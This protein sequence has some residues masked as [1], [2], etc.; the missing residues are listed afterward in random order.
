MTHKIKIESEYIGERIDKVLA[1]LI[2]ELSRTMISKLCEDG[3]ITVNGDICS[4]KYAVKS[5]DE[6]TVIVP[7]AKPCEAQPQDIDI[8]IVYMDDSVVVVNKPKGMVV[9]PANGNEDGTL[10]NALLHICS[11][12]L[13][14]IGG[15]A[16]PGIVHRIDKDTSGL[17][18]VA[19]NDE[20]HISLCE[21]FKEHSLDRVYHAIVQ[22]RFKDPEGTIEAPIGRSPKDR[23]KMAVVYR[24][25]KSAVTHYKVLEELGNYSYIQCVLETGRT[26]QIR[27]HMAHIGHPLIGDTVYGAKKDPFALEGQCLHA[28]VLGFTHPKTGERLYFDSELPEYF[29]K[30]LTTLRNKS[31]NT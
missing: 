20:A 3:N 24:N 18:V 21:Q 11:G 8:P 28:K 19:K 7:D 5:Q 14:G 12:D 26:H 2:P 10:V 29:Q 23:K 31:Y 16:R 13:S 6:I 17:L 15:V 22:G 25:S 27:V 30:V 9:H 1:S 4:K